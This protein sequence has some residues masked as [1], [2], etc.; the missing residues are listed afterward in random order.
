MLVLSRKPGERIVLPGCDVTVTVLGISGR[1]VRLGVIAPPDSAVHRG[2]TWERIMGSGPG[3][4]REGEP[5]QFLGRGRIDRLGSIDDQ[6]VAIRLAG[7]IAIHSLRF[8]PAVLERGF[9]HGLQTR[10]VFL[11][12][13]LPFRSMR[14]LRAP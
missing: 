11:L 10:V 14:V 9:G 7:E 13:F 6:I 1:R 3:E 8:E 2:E 4:A 5:R 12:E